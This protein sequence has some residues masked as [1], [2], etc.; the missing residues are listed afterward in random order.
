MSAQTVFISYSHQDEAWMKKLLPQLESLR[1]AGVGM[2]VWHDRKIDG[3]DAAAAAKEI[4]RYMKEEA[5]AL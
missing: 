1:Q 2:E 3:G 5:K 4:V